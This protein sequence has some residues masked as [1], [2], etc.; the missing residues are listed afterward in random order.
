MSERSIRSYA[1]LA[2]TILDESPDRILFVTADYEFLAAIIEEVYGTSD[3]Q[4]EFFCTPGVLK[5]L[6]DDFVVA[7]RLREL[8]VEEIATVRRSTDDDTLPTLCLSSDRVTV[9][10]P[11]GGGDVT[12]SVLT[13]ANACARLEDHYEDRWRA[14]GPYTVDVPPYSAV[15]RTLEAELDEDVQAAFA[16]GIEATEM[17]DSESSIKPIPLAILFAARHEHELRS[18]VE[19]ATTVDL[20]SQGT[21]SRAKNRLESI[22]LVTTE[23]VKNGVGRPRQRLLLGD[24]SLRSSS[25]V[26]LTSTMDAL[27][28]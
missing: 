19:W 1:S 11:L 22:G 21:V 3:L 8:D 28:E 23:P 2:Q 25:V 17:R 20:A 26:E 24:E 13:D 15:M 12:T 9:V 4:V 6:E 10:I 18:V 16:T 14:A 7:S 5:R 27:L